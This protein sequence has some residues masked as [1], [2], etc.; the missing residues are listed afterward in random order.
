MANSASG[1]DERESITEP[2]AEEMEEGEVNLRPSVGSRAGASWGELEEARVEILSIPT[3]RNDAADAH[4]APDEEI[5]I[6]DGI[7]V[8]TERTRLQTWV[9]N[10]RDNYKSILGLTILVIASSTTVGIVL[11]GRRSVSREPP[12]NPDI[13]MVEHSVD[14]ADLFFDPDDTTGIPGHALHGNSECD[15]GTICENNSQCIPHPI[16]EG[17]YICDCLAVNN[18]AK[19]KGGLDVAL[20]QFA[21]I[22]CEHKATSYCTKAHAFCTNGGECKLSVGKKEK[23]AGCKCPSGY[24]GEFCQFIEGSM[25]SDW[26]LDNFMHPA[27]ISEYGNNGG[28]NMGGMNMSQTT[29]AIAGTVTGFVALVMCLGSFHHLRQAGPQAG[30]VEG[31]EIR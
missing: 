16:K 20:E 3:A 21:G 12:G 25:P 1:R 8:P 24:E 31:E 17:K 13:D 2:T 19:A 14:P 28:M 15:D 4:L 6:I 26:T 30:G 29:G 7:V 11:D 18:V 9:E 23:H 27:I 22:Y 10:F 5:P